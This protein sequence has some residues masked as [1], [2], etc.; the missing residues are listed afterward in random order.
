MQL[1][2]AL[3]YLQDPSVAICHRDVNPN[4][5]IVDIEDMEDIKLTL[6]DFNVA[7]RFKDQETDNP[8]K[9]MTNTGTPKY[10][11]PEI[12]GGWMSY[13]TAKVDVWSAGAV[14]YYLTC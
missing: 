11:A 13:Y 14:L 3:E 5:I 12:L 9:L 1:L 7:K 2:D 8:I 6:I 4:N 10:K